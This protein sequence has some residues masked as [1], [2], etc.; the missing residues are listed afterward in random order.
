[1]ARKREP[2]RASAGGPPIVQATSPQQQL[3]STEQ[4]SHTFKQARTQRPREREF[5][6]DD[7]YTHIVLAH[8][9]THGTVQ[10]SNCSMG[11]RVREDD[12][13]LLRCDPFCYSRVRE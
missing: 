12:V 7:G 4:T 9:G 8:A 3:L 6:D 1:M 10:L 11:P 5:C 13:T 2:D